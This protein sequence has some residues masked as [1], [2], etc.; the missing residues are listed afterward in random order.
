MLGFTLV[1]GLEPD[2]LGLRNMRGAATL[3]GEALYL[4]PMPRVA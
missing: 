2:R 1:L 4:F 3:M